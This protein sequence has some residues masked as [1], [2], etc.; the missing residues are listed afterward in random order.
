MILAPMGKALR[1][2]HFKNE[3]AL[4]FDLQIFQQAR[5]GKR[6]R[7][8]IGFS[9]DYR[10]IAEVDADRI[11]AGMTHDS[12]QEKSGGIESE[13][14]GSGFRIQHPRVEEFREM[15]ASGA[16]RLLLLPHGGRKWENH[17]IQSRGS[18][19]LPIRDD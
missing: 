7:F 5:R 6:T 13:V 4:R 15:P 1:S 17:P 12:C 10:L 18:R 11:F 14:G 3:V 8:S 9:A 19:F 16:E 2:T